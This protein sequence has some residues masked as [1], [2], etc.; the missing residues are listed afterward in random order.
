MHTNLVTIYNLVAVAPIVSE[1][2]AFIQTDRQTD[3]A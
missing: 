1:K 3:M 2:Y